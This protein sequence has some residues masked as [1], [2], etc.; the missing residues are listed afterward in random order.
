MSRN[1]Q[2]WVHK[3]R[4]FGWRDCVCFESRSLTTLGSV[5]D[6]ANDYAGK[7]VETD[8]YF[9]QLSDTHWGFSAPR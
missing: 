9:V 1:G 4:G 8:F 7:K 3:T 5:V 6:Y 2:A